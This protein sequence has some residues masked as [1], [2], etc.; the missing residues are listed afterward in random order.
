MS[1]EHGNIS[2]PTVFQKPT[3]WNV[4]WG[5]KPSDIV[6][7]MVKNNL[8]RNAILS[9]SYYFWKLSHIF[10]FHSVVDYVKA[11]SLRKKADLILV[12]ISW[13]H[14]IRCR[15]KNQDL[16]YVSCDSSSVFS[17]SNLILVLSLAGCLSCLDLLLVVQC[18]QCCRRQS[19]PDVS[20][21]NHRNV[22]RLFP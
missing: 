20:P 22:I 2:I 17:E 7:L 19:M 6:L 8:K 15:K 18:T 16:K 9:I 5:L 21:Q 11:L 3:S 14:C 12:L 1:R 4:I 13:L 10:N